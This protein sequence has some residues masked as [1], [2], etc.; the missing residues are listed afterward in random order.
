MPY[1]MFET[2]L[3]HC[4]LAW[5]DEGVTGFQLPEETADAT[6]AQL[7]AK[8]NE[9]GEE[10]AKLRGA[11]K[12]V[13]ETITRVRA[14]LAGKPQPLAEVP[15]DFSRASDFDAKIYRALR[16]VPAGKTTTYG[17]LAKKIGSPGG[18]RAVGR[19]MATNPYP[20][21]VPCHRVVA[22]GGKAGGFSAYG[23]ILTK[24][25]LLVLEGGGLTAQ[26]SLFAGDTPSLPFDWK[27]AVRTLRENDPV[28]GK[29]IDRVGDRQLTLKATEGTFAALAE[30][31]VYQQLNGKAAA[32]IFGRVRALYPKG[33]LEPARILATNDED[34]RA[35]GLSANKLASFKDLARHAKA[36]EIP[37]LAELAKMDDETIIDRLT[38]VRG[39]G[40]WTVEMLLIFRL[41]R[42]DVLPLGDYGVQQ[43]FLKTF[44]KGDL[45]KRAERWKPHRSIGSW[46]MWRALELEKIEAK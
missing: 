38:V 11:P 34:L 19:A 17:E 18:S 36:G 6:R 37:T 27:K 21:L 40:R 46:Y 35:C 41:G 23:G 30:S 1:A 15:I 5:N 31:I 29:L 2:P 12:W 26:T 10:N 22:A 3:G 32:T 24:E 39:I 4:A 8:A 28:L 20:L 45:A 7:L 43:G 25:K 13:K 16:A 44:K 42:P 14:H 9:A 33:K